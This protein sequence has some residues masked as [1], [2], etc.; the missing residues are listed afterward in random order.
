V[1]SFGAW[2]VALLVAKGRLLLP[3]PLASWM[4]A[5]GAVPFLR[6]RPGDNAVALLA[7]TRPVPCT[8][9]PRT[10]SSAL[11]PSP[12]VHASSPRGVG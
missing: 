12:S 1:S 8:M 7:V 10:G 6:F 11:R 2:E 4:A 9:I 5:S 3:T